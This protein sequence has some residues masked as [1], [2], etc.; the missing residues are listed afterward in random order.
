MLAKRIIPVLLQRGSTLVKGE[1]F[2]SWRSTGHALQ[3]MRIQAKRSVDELIYL[4]IG[5]TPGQKE[6]DYALLEKLTSMMYTP[7]TVGGGISSVS[8]VN[9]LLRTGAD[10]ACISTAVVENPKLIEDIASHF[11]SQALTVCIDYVGDKV[12]TRCGKTSTG[13]EPL[14]WAKQVERLGAGEIVINSIERDGV[15]SGYDLDMVER[16]ADSV[17]IPVI[18]SGGCS[19]YEDM[20]LALK[21]GATGVAVGALFQFTDATPKGAAL[22]LKEHNVEVRIP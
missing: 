19:G 16:I 13:L 14:S 10:K 9:K 4:D 7:I 1:R 15:M 3:S 21:A 18:A 2:D 8:M 20:R 22:Y 17:D 12:F 11:G 5:A 6:P